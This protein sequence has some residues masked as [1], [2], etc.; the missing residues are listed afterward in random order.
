MQERHSLMPRV[1]N[2]DPTSI[3]AVPGKT[4]IEGGLSL[5]FAFCVLL[6]PASRYTPARNLDTCVA[7]SER[8]QL[9][10]MCV[11]QVAARITGTPAHVSPAVT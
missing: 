10:Y 7:V 11:C 6:C 3:L 2:I 5:L 1:S 9:R 4:S 8:A